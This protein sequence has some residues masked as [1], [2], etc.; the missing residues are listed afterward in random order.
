MASV[1]F[2]SVTYQHSLWRKK[3]KYSQGPAEKH[4]DKVKTPFANVMRYQRKKLQHVKLKKWSALKYQWSPH[5]NSSLP[6]RLL[7]KK[8]LTLSICQV[9]PHRR[10]LACLFRHGWVF[11]PV[12]TRRRASGEHSAGPLL[13]CLVSCQHWGYE[14]ELMAA[15]VQVKAQAS[16]LALLLSRWAL[17]MSG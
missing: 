2:V 5:S 15:R 3:R 4:Q 12:A 1:P 6:F 7:E 8:N 9:A 17:L 13:S 10:L 16:V 14:A 11:A